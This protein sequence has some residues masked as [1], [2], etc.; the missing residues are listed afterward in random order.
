MSFEKKAENDL[1]LI[2]TRVGS[3]E[4]NVIF[5]ELIFI[6]C[7]DREEEGG[8]HLRKRSMHLP[9]TFATGEALLYQ[10]SFPIPGLFDN[11]AAKGKSWKA[12]KTKAGKAAKDEVDPSSLLGAM[13]RQDESVYI[14][15]PASKPKA[16]YRS[17]LFSKEEETSTFSTSV[18]SENWNSVN[19]VPK[20]EVPASFDPLLA[21]LDSLSLENEENCSNSEL[22]NA[23]ENL[24]LN[25]E[26]LELLLLDERMI[27]VEMEPEYVPSLNDLLTNNE[28]LSYVHDSLENGT[29]DGD[30][31]VPFTAPDLVDPIEGSSNPYNPPP[32]SDS[33]SV[34][35]SG[36]CLPFG[37]P[38]RSSPILNLSQQMQEHLNTP[39][40]QQKCL[41][42][43]PEAPV[44]ENSFPR[45]SSVLINA[46]A[47]VQNGHWV[48]QQTLED[49]L[50]FPESNRHQQPWC[51]NQTQTLFPHK[52]E[53][54]DKVGSQNGIY[55]TLQWQGHD[56]VDQLI[57]TSSHVDYSTATMSG[58]GFSSRS[59]GEF[60]SGMPTSSSLSSSS[61]S[62]SS[63]QHLYAKLPA[64]S[65]SY[66]NQN[67]SLDRILP[68]VDVYEMFDS[69]QS[70]DSTHRKVRS[71]EKLYYSLSVVCSIRHSHGDLRF[72]SP[73]QRIYSCEIIFIS[74]YV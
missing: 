72:C 57:T 2:I 44:S 49:V 64:T 73:K 62:F 53:R 26:D 56:Y 9:F 27:Q 54:M 20:S 38:R 23:L 14:C 60:Q 19:Q 13:M 68:S 47:D 25:A 59:F 45:H 36:P 74:V 41:S 50:Q 11:T 43:T 10:T 52:Q 7:A 28:I 35:V 66:T 18:E 6:I 48:P 12:K 37:P 29:S 4:K 69:A 67:S 70:H 32:M 3:G 33:A 16:P 22:F 31:F 39:S 42:W 30:T 34:T 71:N 46:V 17:H 1:F 58:T 21:T 40:L 55:P 8:E 15:Q 61:S 63:Y 24:G 65:C 51:Q 5:S